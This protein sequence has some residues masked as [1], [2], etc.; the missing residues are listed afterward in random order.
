MQARVPPAPVTLHAP[1][2][3][4]LALHIT[5][6]RADGYHDLSSLMAFTPDIADRLHI[7]S[8]DGISLRVDG[9][10]AGL[11]D[12]N[13]D[14]NLI[15]RAVAILAR[16]CGRTPELHIHL[17]KNL[18]VAAGLGGGSADAAAILRYLAAAWGADLN[19][20]ALAADLLTL[21][22]EMPVCLHSAP[23]L[24]EGIGDVLR[25]VAD[26]PKFGI[27]LVNPGIPLSTPQVFARFAAA[28]RYAPPLPPPPR[29]ASATQWID[30]LMPLE[31]GLE[32]AARAL[33]P[34]I[35]GILGHLNAEPACLLARMSGSGATCFGLFDTAA[36]AFEASIRLRNACGAEAWVATGICGGV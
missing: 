36:D 31:N 6:R 17:E 4:N 27:I 24:V 19:R 9:P 22:A 34:Q 13:S 2:K 16:H 12:G 1:A 3:V 18:P 33:C 30:Y 29:G 20:P 7:S 15:T 28:P 32:D 10:M 35:G 8:G 23:A 25:P 26:M 21:G 11:I 14:D 5:G